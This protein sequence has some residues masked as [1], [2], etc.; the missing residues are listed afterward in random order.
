MITLGFMV[1]QKDLG[2]ALIFF[3]LSVT[4]LYL[5]TSKLK[6]VIICV[7]LLVIGGYISYKL[8]G[9]VR[10]RI[11][12]WRDPWPYAYNESHQV[13]QSLISIASG[14]LFGSGLG[15]GHPEFVPVITTDFIFAAICEEMGIIVGFGIIILYFLL[16]YRCMRAAIYVEDS[17]SRLL[18]V[19]YSAMLASQVL[20]IIGGVVNAIPLTGLTL[21]LISYGGS[22]MLTTF[23]ALGILQKISEEA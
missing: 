14:G 21:P 7:F 6:Y 19:G 2:S 15:I 8:F 5:A 22:S 3:G 23:F 9:H 20:V 13:V 17:F 10:L 18:A 12:I 4:V 11:M 16:F 1:L